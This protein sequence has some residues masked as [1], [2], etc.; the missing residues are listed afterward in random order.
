M[1]GKERE[2]RYWQLLDK[3]NDR[4]GT[5]EQSTAS[6]LTKVDSLHVD[7]GSVPALIGTVNSEVGNIKSNKEHI[8]EIKD[9]ITWFNRSLIGLFVTVIL[10]LMGTVYSISVPRT[11]P[12][13]NGAVTSP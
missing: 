10:T 1:F 6:I 9:Q 13:A 3:L 7:L 5:V 11:V 12:P 4:I 8:L 2:E